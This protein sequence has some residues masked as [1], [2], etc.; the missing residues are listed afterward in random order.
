MVFVAGNEYW[1]NEVTNPTP[2]T[3][4]VLDGDLSIDGESVKPGQELTY[5][6][7]YTNGLDDAAD[8]TI[9]DTLP[10]FTEFISAD[11]GGTYAEAENMV[12]W[13]FSGVAS[14]APVEVTLVVK[15]TENATGA[16]IRNKA[17]AN[18]YDTN[19]VVNPV[20]T[21]LEI[22]KDLKDYVDNGEFSNAT[23]A[24]QITGTY[25]EHGETKQ[26]V[27]TVGMEF[28]KSSDVK[29]TV[30]VEGIPGNIE[31]LT[32]EEVYAGNYAPVDATIA[33]EKGEDGI[34]KVSFEN[35]KSDH[36]HKSGVVNNY[37]KGD[38]GYTYQN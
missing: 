14:G 33:A 18:G 27:N 21:N 12:T 7:K 25:V 37:A 19:E 28:T 38:D 8:V 6:I 10:E 35:N 32:V 9:V 26:Y 36:Q 24:F 29:Q 4:S 2:P 5:K 31:G 11:K 13:N 30:I 16:E 17:S 15:V 34:Y 3:K 1:T 22:E 20:T 23:F